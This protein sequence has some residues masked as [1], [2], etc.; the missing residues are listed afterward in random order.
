MRLAHIE[1]DVEMW[2]QGSRR[3][4]GQRAD[5]VSG[6]QR[7]RLCLARALA[8]EPDLLILDEPTSSLDPQSERLIAE[9]LIEL[10][11]RLTMIIIAHRLSTLD[12]C[13]R[14]MVIRDGRL[15]AFSRADEL[16]AT[17]DFYRRAVGASS[18]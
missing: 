5:G 11:G 17:N 3:V 12:V 2:L 9:S 4:I 14:I 7:Q 16:Y 6:G 1:D 8:G 15:E 18:L 10:R 13:D